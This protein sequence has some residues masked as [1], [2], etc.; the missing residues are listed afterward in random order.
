MTERSYLRLI[1][2]RG[3]GRYDVT[4]LFADAAA[5]ATLLDDLARPF[6]DGS[7]DVVA[8][9]DALGFILGAALATRLG[10]GFVPLRKG[11]KLPVPADSASFVDYTGYT[12]SL[13]LRRAAI[14][15][16]AHVLLVDEWIETGAQI[17]AA[18]GL[19]EGQGGAVAAIVTIAM[20]DN[21]TTQALRAGYRC[22]IMWMLDPDL[23]EEGQQE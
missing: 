12:K 23:D 16:G 2:T 6:A 13:E 21:A 10:T 19:I 9:I 14:P 18:I 17:R 4:P 22:H 11:G 5:F 8:G 3:M 15:P 7:I 20:D 1:D